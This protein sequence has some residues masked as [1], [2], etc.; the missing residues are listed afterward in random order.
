MLCME[1]RD[2]LYDA[3]KG[4]LGYSL[5]RHWSALTKYFVPTAGG[6]DSAA[7]YGVPLRV[8]SSYQVQHHNNCW[9]VF[10]P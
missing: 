9:Q 2:E 10:R 6:L 3:G 5:E 7:P 4:R 8:R 1:V